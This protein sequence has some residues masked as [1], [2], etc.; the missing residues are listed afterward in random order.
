V[1][2]QILVRL[3]EA[4]KLAADN[5]IEIL[6]PRGRVGQ[7]NERKKAGEAMHSYPKI[8]CYPQKDK[9]GVYQEISQR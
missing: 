8:H 7:T 9:R 5:V 6:R 4:G 2:V 1:G 3:N